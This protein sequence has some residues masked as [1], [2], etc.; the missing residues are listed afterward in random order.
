MNTFFFT[1][2]TN[3][4]D[5]SQNVPQSY[6]DPS[7]MY[8]GYYWHEWKN[9]H[10]KSMPN[11]NQ[12]NNLTLQMKSSTRMTTM[13]RPSPPISSARTWSPYRGR[14]LSTA[15][16]T[17]VIRPPPPMTKVS[18]DIRPDVDDDIRQS[19]SEVEIEDEAEQRVPERK[20]RKR[21]SVGQCHNSKINSCLLRYF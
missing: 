4:M 13:T 18:L 9:K 14:R 21:R 16:T 2:T 6:F 15:S 5:S 1:M 10:L 20:N 12:W 7:Y 17:S 11:T 3:F 8:I 19:V